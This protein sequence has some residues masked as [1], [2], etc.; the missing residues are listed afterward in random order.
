MFVI[1]KF[2]AKN[3]VASL[4]FVAVANLKFS[5]I[6]PDNKTYNFLSFDYRKVPREFS[7]IFVLLFELY[8]F[9]IKHIRSLYQ[10]IQTSSAVDKLKDW[11]EVE[12]RIINQMPLRLLSCV[13]LASK[14]SSHC[15]A[16]TA[17][18]VRRYLSSLNHHFSNNSVLK[19]EL[20]ILKTVDHRLPVY[21]PLTYVETVLEIL[22]LLF[23]VIRGV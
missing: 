9:M 6:R 10:L 3:L 1:E 17:S 15:K 13:Q 18:K 11:N 16:L 14:L 19:S 7:G 5:I 21:S 4:D 20:R 22:G 2:Q 8:R 12:E 23:S